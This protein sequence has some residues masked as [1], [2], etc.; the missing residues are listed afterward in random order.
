[1]SDSV[2][3]VLILGPFAVCVAVVVYATVRVAS[4]GG[5]NTNAATLQRLD[6]VVAQI[7][8]TDRVEVLAWAIATYEAIA[9]EHVKGSVFIVR[10]ADGT[11]ARLQV[12]P[13]KGKGGESC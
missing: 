5:F 12:A 2:T 3:T 9:G 1:M 11:E 7:G 6:R 4:G 8:A 13:K 10:R